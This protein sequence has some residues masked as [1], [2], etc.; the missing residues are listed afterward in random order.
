M[1]NDRQQSSPP[2]SWVTFRVGR[3]DYGAPVADV[4]QVLPDQCVTL[5]PGAPAHV[6][7]V[8]HHRGKIVTVV[9]GR[10]IFGGSCTIEELRPLGQARILT[11]SARAVGLLV[12][13]VD[14]VSE[15]HVGQRVSAAP[16]SV[17]P[18]Y[19]KFV[20]GSVAREEGVV[21]LIDLPNLI[22]HRIGT[23]NAVPR[24]HPK[25][26]VT[27]RKTVLLEATVET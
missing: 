21:T 19:A 18:A 26:S 17:A 8:I 3:T 27:R 10:G 22:H 20:T 15:L 23:C 12:D 16:D 6:L 4:E 1:F 25:L 24:L 7:G 11:L 14:D 2:S 5:V 9:D 13:H